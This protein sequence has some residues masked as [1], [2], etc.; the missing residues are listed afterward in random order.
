MVSHPHGATQ[1]TQSIARSWSMH[2]DNDRN[3]DKRFNAIHGDRGTAFGARFVAGGRT[4]VYGSCEIV[5]RRID[6]NGHQSFVA[7]GQRESDLRRFAT[8]QPTAHQGGRGS[9]PSVH[10]VRLSCSH[11]SAG[12]TALDRS[13]DS[14]AV[15]SGVPRCSVTPDKSRSNRSIRSA[16]DINRNAA[17]M[18]SH[19]DSRRR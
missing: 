8:G 4:L 10:P 17:G 9:M 5:V 13:A 12:H 19:R 1:Y 16:A 18:W 11:D 14:N 15:S 7:M 6:V 3:R 2:T